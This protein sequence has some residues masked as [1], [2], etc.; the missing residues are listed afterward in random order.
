MESVHRSLSFAS[1]LF[2]MNFDRLVSATEIDH[3]FNGDQEVLFPRF[4]AVVYALTHSRRSYRP[5][6]SSLSAPPE[7]KPDHL[8]NKVKNKVK[9]GG[10]WHWEHPWVGCLPTDSME[11]PE[12]KYSSMNST[13]RSLNTCVPSRD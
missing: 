3:M 1:L 4:S 12:N 2:A 5:H 11:S 9:V 6:R 10:R 13:D 8:L 7:K